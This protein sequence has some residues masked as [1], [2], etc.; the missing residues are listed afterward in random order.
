[1]VLLFEV[2]QQTIVLDLRIGWVHADVMVLLP[3][4]A[5]VIGGPSRGASM[6]FGA[7]LW[8][9]SSSPRPSVCPHW[10]GAWSGSPAASPPWC[11]TA[12]AWWLPPVAAF[13]G[14]RGLRAAVRVA[15][16]RARS[17]PD[18]PRRSAPHRAG[19]VG[20]QCGAR[21]AG[22]APG[23]LG[24]AGVLRPRGSPPRPCPRAPPR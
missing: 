1:M 13:G 18:A 24:D 17:A 14:E 15:R 10:S 3:I 5:G 21:P 9:I 8:P 11:S 7:G 23:G 16:L 6:G 22:H 2:V 12:T 4:L 19:G 20:H